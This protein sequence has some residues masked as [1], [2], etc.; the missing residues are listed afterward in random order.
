MSDDLYMTVC[1][2]IVL[3][4]FIGQMNNSFNHINGVKVFSCTEPPSEKSDWVGG[5]NRGPEEEII[6]FSVTSE[7]RHTTL[8]MDAGWI[9]FMEILLMMCLEGFGGYFLKTKQRLYQLLKTVK[10]DPLLSGAGEVDSLDWERRDRIAELRQMLDIAST[11]PSHSASPRRVAFSERVGL[12]PEW[13]ADLGQPSGW[14]RFHCTQ[15]MPSC[16]LARREKRRLRNRHEGFAWIIPA[17]VTFYLI[18][19]ENTMSSFM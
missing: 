13:S 14:K 15:T 18:F 2:K 10:S 19:H 7:K 5:M 4:Q 11:S 8:E 16:A 17:K 6:F 12:S 9:V 3:F 1:S